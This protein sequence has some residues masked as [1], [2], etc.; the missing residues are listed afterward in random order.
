VLL[1]SLLKLNMSGNWSYDFRMMGKAFNYSASTG[2]QYSNDHLPYSS[3]LTLGDE[4]TV[5]G[6]KDISASGDRGAYVANTI[7]MPQ[8]LSV[9]HNVLQL[10]PF[11]GLD[12]GVA[13]NVNGRSFD[14]AGVA[15]GVRFQA[16]GWASGS[17]T[18]GQPLR[19]PRGFPRTPVIY[20]STNLS[21]LF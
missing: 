5:R 20:L 4:Y 6:F 13:R 15:A 17:L 1:N 9:G 7:T 18:F 11:V 16:L 14:L 12:A 8:V 2:I 10:S 19:S 21:A 3:Q